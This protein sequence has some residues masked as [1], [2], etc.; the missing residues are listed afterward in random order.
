MMQ[1]E[2]S[3]I[4]TK[5][6][7]VALLLFLVSML[8]IYSYKIILVNTDF[9]NEENKLI[10]NCV[11]IR[12]DLLSAN[13]NGSL[14]S[15]ELYNKQLSETILSL[16]IKGISTVNQTITKSQTKTISFLTNNITNEFIEVYP[17]GCSSFAKTIGV[18]KI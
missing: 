12:Y 10:G 13:Y 15:L 4:K 5:I 2:S 6:F 1:G 18:N 7:M 17:N 14:L 11:G 9:S 16:S 8:G 3:G